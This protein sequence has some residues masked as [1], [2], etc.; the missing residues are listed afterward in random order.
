MWICH[1]ISRKAWKTSSFSDTSQLQ[2]N[3]D[4]CKLSFLTCLY[5]N[6]SYMF[7]LVLL[8]T[9][10]KRKG[11]NVCAMWTSL[12]WR[13]SQSLIYN[14]SPLQ[15]LLTFN[16]FDQSIFK[17]PVGS[18][19]SFTEISEMRKINLN[20]NNITKISTGNIEIILNNV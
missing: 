19:V 8:N 1:E 2:R 16:Q 10:N 13:N 12:S 5:V 11:L 17:R 7:R 18:A 3:L 4:K 15:I 20:N 9:Y 14:F 6:T